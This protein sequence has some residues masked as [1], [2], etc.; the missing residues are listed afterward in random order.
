MK[1]NNSNRRR[2]LKMLLSGSVAVAATAVVTGCGLAESLPVGTTGSATDGEPL[3]LD[4]RQALK[5]DPQTAHLIVNIA[6][7]GDEVIIKGYVPNQSDIYNIEQVA[8]AVPG[9]RHVL[10]DLYVQ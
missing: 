8:N 2:A 3:S 9:V 10:I 6:T 7:A 4:V 5:N 1:S